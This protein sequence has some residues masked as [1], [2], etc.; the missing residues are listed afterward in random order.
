MKT[1]LMTGAA[2]GVGTFLRKEFQGR[3]RLRLSDLAEPDGRAADEEFVKAD[4]ADLAATR[5]AVAGVDG[6][7]HMGGYSVEGDWDSILN[8]NIIGTYN[9]FEAAR[10]EGVKRIV[11]A[12]SNHAMGFYDRAETI[13]HAN[14]PRPDSRY[15]VSKV[16]GEALGS[17]YADKYGAE[18]M[19]IRIGNV[20]ARPGDVR[21]LSIWIS[22]RDLAQLVSI[23]LE[24]PDIRCEVVYGMSDNERAWWDNSNAIRLGYAPRDRGED[25]AD[26]V[27]A[28]HSADTGDPL[29][30]ALQGGAFVSAEA[31]GDPT[32]PDT[33]L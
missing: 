25:Y 3:Y 6:I 27:F 23:G 12:S 31:G 24:H 2:G 1:I 17:L 8:A 7:I 9:L 28:E 11:F 21:L 26:E 18:V 22:P 33:D 19:S 5:K 16:F 14:Y 29:A 30:D 15:G 20:A 10:L 13:D 32:K 4:L